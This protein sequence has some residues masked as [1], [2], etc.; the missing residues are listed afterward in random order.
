ME[1]GERKP[2]I[3]GRNRK[4]H[5][6]KKEVDESPYPFTVIRWHDE[7]RRIGCISFGALTH[8]ATKQEPYWTLALDVYENGGFETWRTIDDDEVTS[9]ELLDIGIDI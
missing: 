2:R 1:V 6:R 8:H 4:K 7:Y 3:A 5:I 9:V